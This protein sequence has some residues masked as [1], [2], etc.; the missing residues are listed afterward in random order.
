MADPRRPLTA[1]SPISDWLA[2]I[3]IEIGRAHV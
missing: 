3:E 2:E 1:Q